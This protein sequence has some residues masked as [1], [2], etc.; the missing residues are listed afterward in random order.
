MI[1]RRLLNLPDYLGHVCDPEDEDFE[2][3]T[4]QL[5]KRM[6]HLASVLNHF[7]RRWRLE[8]LS[9]LRESHRYSARKSLSRSPVSKGDVVIV[10]DDTLPR[11]LWKLGRIQELLTGRDGQTRAAVVRVALRDRQHVLL[12]RPVQLL[13]PLEICEAIMGVDSTHAVPN[14]PGPISASPEE[15]EESEPFLNASCANPKK[16]PT[17]AAA[18][19]ANDKLKAWTQ[20]LHN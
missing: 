4:C 18:E 5:T 20:E 11:G 12:R 15:R 3:N 9:E 13:Y 8:Y 7:W 16:R 19:R 14:I 1:G 10:H 2:V 6:K 17:R